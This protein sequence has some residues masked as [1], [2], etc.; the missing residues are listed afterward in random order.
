MKN[1]KEKKM[2]PLKQRVLFLV[3]STGTIL[4]VFLSKVP[5]IGWLESHANSFGCVAILPTRLALPPI[6]V[7]NEESIQLS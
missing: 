5:L 4:F 2:A 1:N 3:L 7:R 6:V